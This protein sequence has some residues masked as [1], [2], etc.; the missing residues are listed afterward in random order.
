M[1]RGPRKD[2]SPEILLRREI[3]K[4][5]EL[6]VE[7]RGLQSMLFKKVQA[8]MTEHAEIDSMLS[9]IGVLSEALKVQTECVKELSKHCL[10]LRSEA[11]GKEPTGEMPLEELMEMIRS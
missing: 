4:T 8:W 5:I 9:T 10:A 11:E 3:R 2:E 7:A 6:S 1:A